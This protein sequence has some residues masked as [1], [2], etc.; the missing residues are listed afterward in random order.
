MQNNSSLAISLQK[1]AV[2][3]MGIALL[4]LPLLYTSLTTDPFTLP[5][6][7]IVAVAAGIA[8]IVYGISMVADRKMFFRATP[9]DVAV[10]LFLVIA[11]ASAVFAVNKIDSLTAF[12]PL[13]FAIILYFS[14]TNLVKKENDIV[15]LVSALVIGALVSTILSVFQFLG[16]YLLPFADTHAQ[17]FTTYDS[18]LDQAIY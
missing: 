4:I 6:Q 18:F 5:K 2:I 8:V 9:F 7:I 14:I 13:L 11:F 17:G 3:I 1:I 15:F 12:F 16:I 10:L